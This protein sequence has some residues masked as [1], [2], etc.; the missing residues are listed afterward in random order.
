MSKLSK[1]TKRISTAVAVVAI[2]GGGAGAAYAYWT[3]TG[4]GAGAGT[5]GHSTAFTVAEGAITGAAL[6]P[7]GPSQTVAFTV[8]NPSTGN[9]NLTG[10]AVTVANSDGSIWN[11]VTGCSAADY[12]IGAVTITPGEIAPGTGR[13]GSVLVTMNDLASNQNACQG[14]AYPLY[15]AAS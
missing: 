15:F 4:T 9:E 1:R 7:G 3:S 12:A 13:T 6:T 2:V 14:V 8:T 5:T 10:V 11:A